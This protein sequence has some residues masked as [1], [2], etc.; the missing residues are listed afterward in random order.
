MVAGR[1]EIKFS[2][3]GVRP[4]AIALLS[5]LGSGKP[6]CYHLIN[7]LTLVLDVVLVDCSFSTFWV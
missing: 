4:A 5:S 7:G 3:Y 1:M 2:C 6:S